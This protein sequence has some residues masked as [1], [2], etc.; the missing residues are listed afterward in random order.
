METS[1]DSDT[2]EP[3]VRRRRITFRDKNG[4]VKSVIKKFTESGKAVNVKATTAVKASPFENLMK[5]ATDFKRKPGRPRKHGN[6]PR[7]R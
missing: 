6:L 7:N 4:N 3:I 5:N 2:E 1:P